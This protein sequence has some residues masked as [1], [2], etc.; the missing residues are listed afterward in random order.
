MLYESQWLTYANYIKTLYTILKASAI[1]YITTS[2]ALHQGELFKNN[3]DIFVY[4]K[5]SMDQHNDTYAV[6]YTVSMRGLSFIV[7]MTVIGVCL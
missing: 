4:S 2:Y 7:I 6:T 5:P 3:I 1:D